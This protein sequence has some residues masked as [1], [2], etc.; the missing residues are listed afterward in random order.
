MKRKKK[1][2]RVPKEG[3]PCTCDQ[4]SQVCYA[5]RKTTRWSNWTVSEQLC[6]AGCSRMTKDWTRE[7]TCCKQGEY[8]I[9][10]SLFSISAIGSLTSLDH[11]NVPSIHRL[12]VQDG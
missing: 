1:E 5:R 7:R 4:G 6:C 12:L 2:K 3:H 9:E 11:T 8:K 10:S